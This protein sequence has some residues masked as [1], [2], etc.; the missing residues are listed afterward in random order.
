MPAFWQRIQPAV[1]T[2]AT[3]LPGA[4]GQDRQ[5]LLIENTTILGLY[6]LVDGTFYNWYEERY[7]TP[8]VAR[9][10]MELDTNA[11]LQRAILMAILQIAF[12]RYKDLSQKVQKMS[13][14]AA[15]HL[16]ISTLVHQ[17]LIEEL[18]SPL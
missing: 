11:Q 7:I 18:V 15:E 17:L 6:L 3:F 12:Q 14:A 4:G 5:G 8:D 13:K 2:L 9:N 10:R 1:E 16:K